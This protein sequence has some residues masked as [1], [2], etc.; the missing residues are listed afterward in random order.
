M[1]RGLG[2]SPQEIRLATGDALVL[3]TDGVTDARAAGG[4]RFGEAR[5]LAALSRRSGGRGPAPCRD[6][7]DEV[8]AFQGDAEPADDIALLVLRRLP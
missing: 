1:F 7:V 3:Y 4:E 8:L 2:V 6:V 5:F